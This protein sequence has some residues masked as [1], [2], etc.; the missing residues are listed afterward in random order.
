MD[1]KA[2]YPS[3]PIECRM[4]FSI[5]VLSS[6]EGTKTFKVAIEPD[7]RR[8]TQIEREGETWFLDKYFEELVPLS[9]FVEKLAGLP[10]YHLSSSVKSTLEYADKRKTAVAH[11]LKTGEYV[12]PTEPAVSHSSLSANQNK[13]FVSFL[14]IDVCG[15]SVLRKKDE[16][17]FERA[18]QILLSEF[19]TLIA[20]S[21]TAPY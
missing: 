16:V 7:L 18:Y 4:D 19:G 6:D 1:K 2:I 3:T 9:A 21:L 17:G 14:S 12:A 10:I 15:S 5:K 11:Q 20:V 8:Y 13:R